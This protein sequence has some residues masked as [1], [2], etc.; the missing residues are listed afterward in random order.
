M[1]EVASKQWEKEK[2][3]F[4]RARRAGDRRCKELESDIFRLQEEM[5]WSSEKIEELEKKQKVQYGA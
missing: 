5:K 4:K 1:Q 3:E 2:E